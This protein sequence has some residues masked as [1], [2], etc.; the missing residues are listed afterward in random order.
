M[1]THQ[2]P[3]FIKRVLAWIYDGLIVIALWLVSGLIAV[4]LSGGT[5]AHSILTQGVMILIIGGYF[6]LSWT[7]LGATAGMRA[8]R[9]QLRTLDGHPLS[10]TKALHR[11]FWCVA[12]G[13]PILL[14]MATL[15]CFS[16]RR[17]LYDRFTDTHMIQLPKMHQATDGRDTRNRSR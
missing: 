9:L 14:G 13:A 17:P 3:H 2:S 1:K 11:L 15:F 8:W 6:I 4:G 12:T 5:V 10:Y 16:D 7:R